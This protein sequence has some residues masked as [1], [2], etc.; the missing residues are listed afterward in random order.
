MQQK[1][2]GGGAAHRLDADGVK[3]LYDLFNGPHFSIF[4][5]VYQGNNSVP[6]NSGTPNCSQNNGGYYFLT[7]YN[8]SSAYDLAT[9]MGSGPAIPPPETPVR[10]VTEAGTAVCENVCSHAGFAF[11]HVL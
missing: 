9:G 2:G 3:T 1:I 11:Y 6:C 5:D 4:Q 10:R 7:G 8:A